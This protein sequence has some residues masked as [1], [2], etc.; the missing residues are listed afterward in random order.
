M[1]LWPKNPK[2]FIN[3]LCEAPPILKNEFNNQIFE[4]SQMKLKLPELVTFSSLNESSCSLLFT[5]ARN[6]FFSA[7]KA[8]WRKKAPSTTKN[9]NLRMKTSKKSFSSQEWRVWTHL[10]ATLTQTQIELIFPLKFNFVMIC[11]QPQTTKKLWN[12]RKWN[13]QKT[14]I[15]QF[16]L[17]NDYFWLFRKKL[18]GQ[19]LKF[20]LKKLV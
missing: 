3:Q 1:K 20:Q 10:F 7:T 6:S 9:L 8:Q 17:I 13:D 15:N 18:K 4:D 5:P 19:A 14:E 12:F 16:R 11:H 2:I